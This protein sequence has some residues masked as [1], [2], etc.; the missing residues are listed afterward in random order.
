MKQFTKNKASSFLN[1]LG[2]TI[3]FA[4][5]YVIMSQVMYDLTYNK[6]IKDKDN[7][8]MMC[9]SYD[10]IHW[11]TVIPIQMSRRTAEGVPGAQIGFFNLQS[12]TEEVYVGDGDGDNAKRYKMGVHYF[13]K[14]GAE[15]LGVRFVTGSYPQPNSGV[16][17]SEKAAHVMSVTSGDAIWIFDP[18]NNETVSATVSGVFESF[19]ENTDFHD[20]DILWDQETLIMTQPDDNYSFNGLV[21]FANTDDV[22]KFEE[23][24]MKYDRE[25]CMD[26][27]SQYGIAPEQQEAV[28]A[29]LLHHQKLTSL[30]DIHFSDV[31]DYVNTRTTRSSVYVLIAIAFLII[32]IAFI[33]FVNFFVSLVPEKMR[34]VN[35]RKVFGASRGILVW[36]FIK[37]AL[38]Y[39]GLAIVFSLVL[40]LAISKSP[41]GD[42]TDGG[43]GLGNNMLAFVV[44]VLVS[45]VFAAISALFP[46]IY[47]TN[48]NAAMGVKSGFSSSAA[49]K[50]IRKV[51]ITLQL[52]VAVS[53]MIISTVFFMQ[54]RHMTT[55]QLG[56]DK[57]NLYELQIPSYSPSI[58]SRLEGISGVKAVTACNDKIT[59]N[60]GLQQTMSKPDGNKI[61]LKT[62]YVLP[63]YLD[64][65]GLA[66]VEGERFNESN[67]GRLILD[68]GSKEKWDEFTE[69][70][71]AGDRGIGF[72]VGT[73]SKPATD[74]STDGIEAYCNRGYEP[75]N[76]SYLIFRTEEGVDAKNVIRQVV[77]AVCEEYDL[78]EA[79]DVRTV[80]DELAER[81]EHFKTQSIVIGL[82]SI[83]AIIISL[84][85]VFGIVLFET[86]HRRHETAV[87][88]VL[89]A[90]GS[91]IVRL[92]CTQYVWTVVAAC[93]MATPVAMI[94]TRRWLQQ[95]ITQVY[96]S[97]LIYVAAFAIVAVLTLG[98]IAIRT[99]SASKEN[100]VNNLKSE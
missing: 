15:V 60:A 38:E 69:G 70:I 49:G 1:V 56:F 26:M 55:Q 85:G 16:A 95:F 33:N 5:F 12:V 86:E 81:Y 42:L 11:S 10:E 98:I 44:M 41:V 39:V 17:I 52:G 45:A 67:K 84:M 63:N 3:A 91:D 25:S 2:M 32:I 75:Q 59:G 31:N 53:M 66:M 58:K 61:I 50:V 46:A 40:I 22:E 64:V 97:P 54:Y 8:Y 87:R 24:F 13:T 90:E 78:Y 74:M 21:R 6:G 100:L 89:G 47:V 96:V 23:L 92:F 65:I 36:G 93:L 51:L 82:F 68:I 43:I 83:I 57:E 9:L 79:P 94:V 99:A 37:E 71:S 30:R 18:L 62:R 34:S 80:D 73:N 35:I 76:M 28:L 19:A 88:K 14:S 20:L 29:Q 48:V 7:A 77:D 4:A 27:V 72:C